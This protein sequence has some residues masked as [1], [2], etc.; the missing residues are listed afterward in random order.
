MT[1][2]VEARG[3]G[4][5]AVAAALWGTDAL[6][7]RGLALE[8]PAVSVVAWEHVV[9]AAVMV[10]PVWRA[11]HEARALTRGE[12]VALVVIGAG[13]STTATVAFTLSLSAGDPTTPLLL[14]KV[15]PLVAVAASAVLLGER[16]GRRYWALLGPALV[17]VYLLSFPDP[18]GASLAVA[19]PSLLA[20]L[21]AALWA[22]GTV[23]GRRLSGVLSPSTLMGW[24]FVIGLPVALVLVVALSPEQVVPTP[25]QVPAVVLLALVPGAAAMLLY[26]RGLRE[27]PAMLATVAELAFPLTA[28]LVNRVA[29]GAVLSPTQWVGLALLAGCVLLLNVRARR[30]AAHAGV[31]VPRSSR[32]VARQLDPTP[33]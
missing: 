3:V 27:T 12:W 29:F 28:I 32:G 16:P 9:L 14:Q 19:G 15:Q 5:V 7:R 6:F 1:A 22:L 24:R 31:H 2:R 33:T 13:A 4:L 26:Y 17:G 20:L 23:L 8:A 18:L 21:A 30:G 25:G 10:I 11:R